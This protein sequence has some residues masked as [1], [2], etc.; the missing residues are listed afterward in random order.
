MN[1]SSRVSSS[2]TGRPVLS[3]ASAKISSTNI[4]CL[5]PKPPP[6][7][8]QN[9][10]TL[11]GA[12]SK[13]SAS[14]RRVRNGVCVLERTLRTLPVA[15]T[16]A[17]P[18]WV[19]RARVLDPL[20]GERALVGD[21]GLRQ[22]G[23][24]IAVFAV[25]FRHDVALRVGDPLLRRL[26]AVNEGRARRD[27]LRRIDHRRQNI[28][29]DLEAAAAFLGGGLGLRDHGGDLLSDEADDI[30]EHAGVVRVHPGLFVPRGGEQ[31]VRRVFEGQH[32]MHAGN[33]QRRGLVD[34][35]DLWRADAASAA[36]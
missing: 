18:P 13:I 33:G 36:S 10:R 21:G 6:T 23:G 1:C 32:R 3:A 20:G 34:R 15:S 5:P 17:R 28:V 35:D 31:A 11:S 24:D 14:A 22:R 19:S 12:R 27:R 16:Q 29:V 4:S 26:V 2:L 8:S 25:G 30:V 7:R 9:T